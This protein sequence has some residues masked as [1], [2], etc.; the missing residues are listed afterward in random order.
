MTPGRAAI[1]AHTRHDIY[2]GPADLA[3]IV[4]EDQAAL[5]TAKLRRPVPQQNLL[6][7]SSSSSAW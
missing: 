1:E 5:V 7:G 4:A 3:R 6:S 2:A